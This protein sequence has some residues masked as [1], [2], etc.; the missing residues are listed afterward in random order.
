MVAIIDA[1]NFATT[2]L[3]E[4]ITGAGEEETYRQWT[5]NDEANNKKEEK[6]N[7][8]EDL[9]VARSQIDYH[10]KYY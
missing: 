4:I 3:T 10:R 8:K 1:T 5:T 9:T 2:G 6:E 7:K